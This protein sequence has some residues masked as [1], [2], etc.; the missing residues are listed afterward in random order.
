MLAAPQLE[1]EERPQRLAMIR[2]PTAMLAQQSLHVF[3]RKQSRGPERL[4]TQ[5]VNREC[6]ERT[7]QPC[8][9]RHSEP[10]LRTREDPRWKQIARCIPQDSLPG[11]A[12]HAKLVWQ[13]RSKFNHIPG[14]EGRPNLER[15]GHARA[16][17]LC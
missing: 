14:E 11:E 9:D 16:I 5:Q 4:C 7:I 15:D 17:D 2:A 13:G 6:P 8:R 12:A 3:R 1:D 10:L